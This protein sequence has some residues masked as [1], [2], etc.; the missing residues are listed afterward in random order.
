VTGASIVF[1]TCDAAFGNKIKLR[2]PHVKPFSTPVAPGLGSNKN[3]KALDE[4]PNPSA[5]AF[6]VN[7]PCNG[8]TVNSSL[9][10]G[11]KI[12]I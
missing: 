5:I 3:C 8:L 4:S 2:Y 10:N 7:L 9:K 6:D 12:F 11:K 1:A